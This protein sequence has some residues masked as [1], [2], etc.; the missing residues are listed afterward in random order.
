MAQDAVADTRHCSGCAYWQGRSWKALLV[1]VLAVWK[2]GLW[3][4]QCRKGRGETWHPYRCT[5]WRSMGE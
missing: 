2:G 1:Q 4:G 3:V 5:Q